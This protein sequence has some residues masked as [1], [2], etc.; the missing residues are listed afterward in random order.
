MFVTLITFRLGPSNLKQNV[1][2]LEVSEHFWYKL[3]TYHLVS[4]T[5]KISLSRD[6]SLFLGFNRLAP[7]FNFFIFT[8]LRRRNSNFVASSFPTCRRLWIPE[9]SDIPFVS[10]IFQI[11]VAVVFLGFVATREKVEWLQLEKKKSKMEIPVV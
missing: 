6:I 9:S 10:H 7:N 11:A 3:L 5:F 2:S 8:K 4:P 1:S